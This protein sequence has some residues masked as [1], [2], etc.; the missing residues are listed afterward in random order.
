M[1]ICIYISAAWNSD[2][3]YI[4]SRLNSEFANSPTLR[5]DETL[6]LLRNEFELVS[7]G[8]IFILQTELP[9][10]ARGRR[11]LGCPCRVFCWFF[12]EFPSPA[13]DQTRDLRFNPLPR[14]LSIKVEY[15]ARMCACWGTCFDIMFVNFMHRGAILNRRHTNFSISRGFAESLTNCEK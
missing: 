10:T 1:A 13:H 9:I 15:F 12:L 4:F 6:V 2:S 7:R 8:K 14:N 3:R 5:R 11:S